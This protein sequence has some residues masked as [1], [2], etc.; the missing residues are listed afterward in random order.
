MDPLQRSYSRR[1]LL[2]VEQQIIDVLG[3]TLDEYWE[4]CRLADCKAKERRSEY[5]LIPEI[6][7]TGEPLTTSQI[8]TIALSFIFTAASVLLAPKPQVLTRALVQFVH[9]IFVAKRSL[10][11]CLVLT[12][13]RT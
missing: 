4:F 13:C 12:A 7:A 3:L 11:S 1:S 9:Q 8:I 6:S 2:P 10:L 5:A